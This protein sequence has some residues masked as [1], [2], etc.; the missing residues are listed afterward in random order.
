[1]VFGSGTN[2]NN[3]TFE[4]YLW[5][6]E[7]SFN[8]NNHDHRQVVKISVG[9]T[10]VIDWNKNIIKYSK[11]DEPYIQIMGNYGEFTTPYPM[12]IFAHKRPTSITGGKI[13]IYYF[14]FYDND[15]LVRNF[16]PVLDS[17][18]VPCMYDL[19]EGKFYYNAGTGGFT[20]GPII[21]E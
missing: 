4:F 15:T 12:Y 21:G 7:L 18:G 9:D 11:N 14:Q 2:F 19:V 20:A 1:M 6:S 5:S 8:Y 17:D 10:I 3:N 16:I 13:K